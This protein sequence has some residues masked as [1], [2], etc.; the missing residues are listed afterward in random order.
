MK[1]KFR[2]S[3]V[4][5]PNPLLFLLHR[6]RLTGG[7]DQSRRAF[8]RRFLQDFHAHSRSERLNLRVAKIKRSTSY[9]R[10]R[11]YG[12]SIDEISCQP[13]KQPAIYS[14]WLDRGLSQREIERDRDRD[15]DR[16]R[17]RERERLIGN[18][19]IRGCSLPIVHI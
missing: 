16:E 8:C 14:V 2:G 19:P 15:R 3:S 7:N 10:P 11:H 12:A 4:G 13:K 9:H 18:D 5:D 6:P 17:E 1:S